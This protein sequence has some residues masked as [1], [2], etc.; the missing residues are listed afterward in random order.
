MEAVVNETNN[1]V[2]QILP[3]WN[4]WGPQE[5][6]AMKKIS[7]IMGWWLAFGTLALIA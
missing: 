6:I 1:L 7:E 2:R 5:T 3:F 4:G